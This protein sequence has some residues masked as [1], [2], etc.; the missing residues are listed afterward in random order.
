MGIDC[1][2]DKKLVHAIVEA[3]KS[4]ICSMGWQ[5]GDSEELRLQFQ[6]ERQQ[7]GD[8]GE[9]MFQSEFEDSLL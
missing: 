2:V 1:L 3:C 7:G 8:P 4:Q 6:S 5:V 9:L